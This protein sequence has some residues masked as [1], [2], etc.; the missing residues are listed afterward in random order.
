M[1]IYTALTITALL[2]TPLAVFANAD[3]NAPEKALVEN[4]ELIEKQVASLNLELAK[5]TKTLKDEQISAEEKAAVVKKMCAAYMLGFPDDCEELVQTLSNILKADETKAGT[6]KW[7]MH[8]FITMGAK[9]SKAE[10]AIIHH[11]ENRKGYYQDWAMAALASVA[12]K[13]DFLQKRMNEILANPD[14][15]AHAKEEAAFKLVAAGRLDDKVLN[16]LFKNAEGRELH[17]AELLHVAEHAET[18]SDADRKRFLE[19]VKEPVTKSYEASV[20]NYFRETMQGNTPKALV[21]FAES[22]NVESMEAYSSL[23]HLSRLKK[24]EFRLLAPV[25][26][27]LMKKGDGYGSIAYLLSDLQK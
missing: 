24:P 15:P 6:Q 17:I 26:I 10:N 1:K 19:L 3:P 16:I 18:L 2:S 8:M 14:V 13:N 25:L 22:L 21:H 5:F 20:Q 9:A 23:R 7:I 12:P 4:R 27:D 11:L